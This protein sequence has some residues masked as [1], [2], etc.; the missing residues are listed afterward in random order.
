MF[1]TETK[2]IAVKLIDYLVRILVFSL[3]DWLVDRLLSFRYRIAE[4]PAPEDDRY[5]R[6]RDRYTRRRV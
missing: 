4:K 6:R 3:R 5:T 1:V 2:R